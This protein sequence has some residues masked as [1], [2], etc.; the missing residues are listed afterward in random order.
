MDKGARWAIVHR[1]T[2]SQTLLVTKHV[3]VNPVISHFEFTWRRKVLY[4]LFGLS[5][6]FSPSVVSDSLWPHELQHSRHCCP[7]PTP[8]VHPNP[9]PLSRR[10]HP[11]ISSCV[12]PFSSC[13]QSFPA[14][15]SFPMSQL[16]AWGGQSI[17]A[18]ASAK[19]LPINIQGWLPLGF[20]SLIL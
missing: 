4:H 8:G 1:V 11:A 6:Q 3:H 12:I 15:G 20:T 17:G 14:L 2:K 10:F 19:V 7:S 16:F 9:C 5:V 18:S 13:P